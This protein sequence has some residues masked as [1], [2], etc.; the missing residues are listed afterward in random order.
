MPSV[1]IFQDKRDLDRIVR[2]MNY[3]PPTYNNLTR[4][5]TILMANGLGGWGGIPLGRKAFTKLS[6]CPV[7]SCTLVVDKLVSFIFQVYQ[8]ITFI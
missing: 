7:N 1:L 3:V 4:I 6:N 2:Q 5:K 8:K